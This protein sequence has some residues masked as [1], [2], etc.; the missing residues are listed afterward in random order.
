MKICDRPDWPGQTKEK[1]R[2]WGNQMLIIEKTIWPR[3]TQ[4][5][6]DFDQPAGRVNFKV[7]IAL[8][9]GFIRWTNADNHNLWHRW[10]N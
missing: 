2:V 5:E 7:S 8:N 3:E 10:Y 6:K 9:L 4:I 1:E